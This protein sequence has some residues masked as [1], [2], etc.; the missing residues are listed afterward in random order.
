ML[1]GDVLAIIREFN[2]IPPAPAA[3]GGANCP[4]RPLKPNSPNI[5]LLP[6][7][8]TRLGVRAGLGLLGLL[9]L[10]PT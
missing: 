10:A 3:P 8:S 2:A 6:R 9:L 4:K 7:P 5:P 1:V